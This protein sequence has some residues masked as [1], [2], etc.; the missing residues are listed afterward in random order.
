[1]TGHSKKSTQFDVYIFRKMARSFKF[2]YCIWFI[3]NKKSIIAAGLAIGRRQLLGDCL[4]LSACPCT[5]PSP[6][7]NMGSKHFW[8]RRLILILFNTCMRIQKYFGTIVSGSLRL[9]IEHD[10]GLP[11][12]GVYLPETLAETIG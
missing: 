10:F 12:W 7:Q 2:Y 1:M 9:F 6:A 8:S 11:L 5:P 3:R 4:P